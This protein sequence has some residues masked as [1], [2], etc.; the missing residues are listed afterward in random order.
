ML[1]PRFPHAQFPHIHSTS[2]RLAAT[3][4]A[5]KRPRPVLLTYTKLC[6]QPSTGNFGKLREARPKL[7]AHSPGFMRIGRGASI[8]L[9]ASRQ[10]R[11]DGYPV[12][13]V[14]SL[15]CRCKLRG[16]KPPVGVPQAGV[17][18]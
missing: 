18:K 1:Q 3:K 5:L 2:S 7:E 12:Y 11:S 10:L 4:S 13:A 17:G 9:T 6:C 15:D 14:A 8:S 16:L